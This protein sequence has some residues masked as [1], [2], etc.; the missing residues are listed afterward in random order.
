MYGLFAYMKGEKWLHE[1]GELAG[2][3][4]P[5]HGA[6]GKDGLYYKV[7]PLPVIN[8]RRYNP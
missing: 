4:F 2:Y 6:S 5:F 7:G 3:I 1:Q 8:G